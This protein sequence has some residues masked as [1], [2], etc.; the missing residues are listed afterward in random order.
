[1]RDP[2]TLSTG[3]TYDREASRGGSSPATTRDGALPMRP[4]AWR[5]F[6]TASSRQQGSDGPAPRRV[7]GGGAANPAR[8]PSQTPVHRR[9]ERAQQAHCRVRRRPHLLVSIIRR[10]AAASS[11]VDGC[12]GSTSGSALE[13]ALTILHTLQVSPQGFSELVERNGDLVEI[14]TEVLRSSSYQTRVYAVILLQSITQ[15]LPLS[16]LVNLKKEIFEELK[17]VVNDQIS[18]KASKAALRVLSQLSIWGKNRAK[19]TKAGGVGVILELLLDEQDGKVCEMAMVVL[20]QLCGC[21]EGRAELKILRVS[22]LATER[23]VKVL[24]SVA[25]FS[26]APAVVQEMLHVGVVSKLCLLLQLDCGSKTKEKTKE[27][28]RLHARMWKD[29]PCIPPLLQASYACY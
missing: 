7:H 18:L 23:A 28:L 25:K 3:V 5:D 11:A 17:S 15:A 14:F 12:T 29:S 8:C 24:Y 16:Q 2:V 9:R 26:A 27:I 1:M 20:D 10:S 19:V 4:A 22:Q 13:E 21:A 6:H